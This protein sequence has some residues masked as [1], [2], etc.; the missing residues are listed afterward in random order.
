M[1]VSLAE[2]GVI[3]L[4]GCC[5]SED[6]ETLL[7]FLVEDADAVVDWRDCA[8]A[9]TAVVQVL[10]AAGRTLRGPPSQNILATMVEPALKRR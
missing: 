7:R 8:F 10:V 3:A 1:T 2:P 6:A 5:P 9:H 4:S